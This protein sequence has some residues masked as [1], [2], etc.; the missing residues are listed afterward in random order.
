MVAVERADPAAAR[1]HL[2]R[3][4]RSVGARHD[5]FVS[6][7]VPL[8]RAVERADRRDPRRASAALSRVPL[9][10]GGR[11][12]PAWL[13]DRV[14][15]TAAEVHLECGNAEA[16]AAALDDVGRRSAE[17]AVLR[18]HLLL[19]RGDRP[20]AAR[21]L[22]AVLGAEG[23]VGSATVEA[24]LLTARVH[25]AEG[26]LPAVRVALGRALAAEPTLLLL[27]EPTVGVDP[28]LRQTFWGYFRVLNRQGVTIVV[29]SH[30]MD[31]ADRCDRLGLIRSGRLL[32]AASPSEIR[33]LAG[34]DN[35]EKAFLALS[36]RQAQSKEEVMR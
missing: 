13:A 27:D 9:V 4:E 18:S 2:D 32:A 29:S 25:H 3:A 6:T 21:L 20:E 23:T 12:L 36:A 19:E 33:R 26:Q 35:L 14:A 10:V 5:P 30:V 28:Q 15:L 34:E 1:S 7:F 8:V 17:W 24:W 22:S 31:E 11:P 16:V